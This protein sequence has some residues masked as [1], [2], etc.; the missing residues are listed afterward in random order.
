MLLSLPPTPFILLKSKTHHSSITSFFF[1]ERRISSRDPCVEKTGSRPS[2]VFSS[3]HHSHSVCR[4]P[5]F[6]S[7]LFYGKN[8]LCMTSLTIEIAPSIVDS[9]RVA[10]D[11]SKKP[12]LQRLS[13]W[14][15]H[16][17]VPAVL[18]PGQ[19]VDLPLAVPSGSSGLTRRGCLTL[20]AV[21]PPLPPTSGSPPFLSSS[22]NG[23]AP[24]PP[25]PYDSITF[26]SA[27]PIIHPCQPTDL[28]PF[29]RVSFRFLEWKPTT[30]LKC[31]REE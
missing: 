11:G 14:M 24:L 3:A 19:K 2:A 5:P 31:V 29:F 8:R 27:L 22:E 4:E 18:F 9:F 10:V 1:G 7:L 13:F 17:A 20:R 16:G 30:F 12:F 6:A 21:K 26:D 28:D 23:F 15:Y 25:A